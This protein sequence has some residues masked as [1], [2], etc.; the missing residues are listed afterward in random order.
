MGRLALLL[1]FASVLR[2]V[3]DPRL[4]AI[5]ALLVPMRTAPI[6]EAR[7]ATLTLTEVKH[8]LRD[9]VE[10][11]LAAL[12]WKDAG[13]TISPTVLHEQLNDELSHADLF[14]PQDAKCW[15]NGLG[16][17]DRVVLETQSGFLVVRTSIG[18]QVCGTD[19]SAYIYESTDNHWQRIWQS[20]QKQLRRKDIL[21]AATRRR[22]NLTDRLAPGI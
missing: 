19:D 3:D 21:S 18:I 12:Q 17:L 22:Q 5:H 20:E 11:R 9:W 8:Q 13:W 7:G 4:A 16:Y 15:D 10:S 1:L 2:A 14:C 6:A